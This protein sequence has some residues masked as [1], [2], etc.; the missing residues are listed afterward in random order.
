MMGKYGLNVF[1]ASIQKVNI[2]S[3]PSHIVELKMEMPIGD[4]WLPVVIRGAEPQQDGVI[5]LVGL[6]GPGSL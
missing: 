2:N 5:A 1:F 3:E 4:Y 6:L